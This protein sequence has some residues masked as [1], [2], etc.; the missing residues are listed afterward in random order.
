[1][2]TLWLEVDV[3][4]NSR[5]FCFETAAIKSRY[6]TIK[7]SGKQVVIFTSILSRYHGCEQIAVQQFQGKDCGFLCTFTCRYEAETG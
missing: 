2:C 7:V 6:G 1:M 5:M 4:L 3:R